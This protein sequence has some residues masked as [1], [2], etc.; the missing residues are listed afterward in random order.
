MSFFVDAGDFNFRWN[1]FQ[2]G[3]SFVG[4]AR[5]AAPAWSSRPEVS[6]ASVTDTKSMPNSLVVQG[7]LSDSSE[8][9]QS[10]QTSKPRLHQLLDL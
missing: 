5:A 2:T 8:N 4:R 6:T 1:I 9:G 7:Q 10:D 3:G